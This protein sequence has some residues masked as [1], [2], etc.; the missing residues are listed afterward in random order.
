MASLLTTEA[1]IEAIKRK[2]VRLCPRG[3]WPRYGNI[4]VELVIHNGMIVDP[5]EVGI[6]DK[7]RD[8]TIE[9]DA[10]S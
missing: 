3:G 10:E 1:I 5:S 8:E 9:D 4:S 6:K 7:S 2:L